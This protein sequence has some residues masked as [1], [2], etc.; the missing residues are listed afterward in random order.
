MSFLFLEFDRESKCFYQRSKNH[1][2]EMVTITVF[3]TQKK[4]GLLSNKTKNYFF[5]FSNFS[6]D[7][8]NIKN[9]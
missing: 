5:I 8:E 2:K 3:K 4:N 7:L 6:L 1:N 9:K